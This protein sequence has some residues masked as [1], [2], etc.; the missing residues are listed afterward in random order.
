MIHTIETKFAVNDEVFVVLTPRKLSTLEPKVIKGT[1]SMIIFSAVSEEEKVPAKIC[2][3]VDGFT[4]YEEN[5]FVA[6]SEALARASVLS[7]QRAELMESAKL[8]TI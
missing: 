4:V 8:D 6:E 1:V 2:Y 5:V 7:T 3:K